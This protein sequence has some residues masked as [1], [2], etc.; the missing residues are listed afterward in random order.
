MTEK[1][2]ATF[3]RASEYNQRDQ[4]KQQKEKQKYACQKINPDG[5]CQYNSICEWPYDPE[6]VKICPTLQIHELNYQEER[7]G[8]EN[9][10]KKL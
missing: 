4:D 2:L 7:N 3:T 8:D 6:L 9:S 5:T 1:N 10:A